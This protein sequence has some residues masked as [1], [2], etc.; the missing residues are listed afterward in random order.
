MGLTRMAARPRWSRLWRSLT[1]EILQAMLELL[2][3]AHDFLDGKLRAAWVA[4]P[5]GNRFA[6]HAPVE[7]VAIRSRPANLKQKAA[8]YD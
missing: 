8:Y 5:D 2:R 1:R 6:L 4:D 3:P 7:T